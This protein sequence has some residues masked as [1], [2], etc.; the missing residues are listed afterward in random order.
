MSES[1]RYELRIAAWIHDCGKI[2]TPESVMD[3][4]TKLQTIYDRIG[5]VETRF[6]II[7][8]DYEIEYLKACAGTTTP[9]LHQRYR[10]RMKALDD[11]LVFIRR[12]NHGG[13]SMKIE[14]QERVRS[15]AAI[16]WRAPDGSVQGLLTE[17]EIR[18]LTIAKG[19]LLPEERTIINHHIVAT[20]R[21]L[22]S[23]PYPKHLRRVPEF[24]GGHHERMDGKGYPKGL[25]RDQ[26]SVQ[27]RIM[28][29]ADIFE[30][31]TADDRPYKPA[32]RLSTAL[33]ILGRMAL[34]GHI[35]P[36]LFAVFIREG[37][38]SEYA[39]RF[40]RPEQIDAVN[41]DAV[42]GYT[43]LPKPDVA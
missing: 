36:D 15:I 33:S 38:Y 42:P 28:G 16:T 13:E 2:T 22:E 26:M 5:L 9:E 11:D 3:K 10:E 30:A 25:K 20:I 23:L 32:M 12:I 18:N 14:D 1:D 21:M 17:N 29:I 37:V 43:P 39:Q 24:A 4:A 35:D 27:A 6:E 34:E 40:L 8:R 31:L 41:L 19:T 7:R